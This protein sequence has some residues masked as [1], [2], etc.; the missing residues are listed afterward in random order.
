MTGEGVMRDHRK[1]LF[2]IGFF[3]VEQSG[4][5]PND[6]L[7]SIQTMPHRVCADFGDI[8]QVEF[9][10][11]MRSMHIDRVGTDME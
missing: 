10:H 7:S 9:L 4:K 11:H 6:A 3:H 8:V 2:V 5:L 1:A